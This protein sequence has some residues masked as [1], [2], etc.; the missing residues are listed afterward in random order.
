MAG[1]WVTLKHRPPFQEPCCG[2]SKDYLNRPPPPGPP[3][4]KIKIINKDLNHS[5]VI[6]FG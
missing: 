4:D 3:K 2:Q 5:L 1:T 6:F